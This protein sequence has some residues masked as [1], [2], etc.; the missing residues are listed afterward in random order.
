MVVV[1]R[2]YVASERP[3]AALAPIGLPDGP[4]DVVGVMRW[5]EPPGW[6]VTAH[7]VSED[8]WFVRDHIAMAALYDWGAVAPFYIDQ[9]SPA[10]TG[11]VPRPSPLKVNLRNE[12]LQYA[13]TWFGLAAVL[14]I[15]FGFWVRSGRQPG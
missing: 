4:H 7:S 9:E 11:G 2:G 15:A 5:P 6:F 10:P 13:F 8:L 1:N 12:H 3:T 14:A